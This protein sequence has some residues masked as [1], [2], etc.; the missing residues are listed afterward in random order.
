MTTS[1]SVV[2]FSARSA[3]TLIELLTVIAI[4]G[5]LA[6]IL[7]PTVGRVRE[8]ARSIQCG[9]NMRQITMALRLYAQDNRNFFPAASGRDVNG[10]SL[11]W[12]KEIRSYLPLQGT[13]STAKEHPVFVCPTASYNG[14]TGSALS[15]TYTVTAAMLG[16]SPSGVLGRNSQSARS[17]SSIDSSRISRIPLLVE[18][19]ASNPTSTTAQSNFSWANI[20]PD[21]ASGAPATMT[22]LDFRHS[23]KMNIAYLDGSVRISD[24][25][26]A[27]TFDQPLWEGVR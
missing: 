23:S 10:V 22:F 1:P 7:I 12:T 17:V 27:K 8:S 6:A 20:Q 14:A 25:T 26:S 15:S 9:S 13:A 24:V 2:R 16:P 21:L 3:F 18:G 19:K 5:I 4:I 11:L